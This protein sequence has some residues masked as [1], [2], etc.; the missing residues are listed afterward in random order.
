MNTHRPPM[1]A[2]F[3]N[4]LI[5]V[6]SGLAASLLSITV[7]GATPPAD[8][9]ATVSISTSVSIAAAPAG[10]SAQDIA[11]AAALR[12]MI[13]AQRPVMAVPDSK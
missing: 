4:T 5:M 13:A 6:A 1:H 10:P 3:R 9:P 12:A 8:E 11:A 7:Y 2:T